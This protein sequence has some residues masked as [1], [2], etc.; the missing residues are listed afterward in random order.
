MNESDAIMRLSAIA[1]RTRMAVFRL[2]VKHGSRGLPATEIARLISIPPTTMSTHLSVLARAELIEARR[3]SR[4]IFYAVRPDGVQSLLSFLISDC[5]EGR[6]ELCS[7]SRAG[8]S[9][10]KI[11]EAS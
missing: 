7:P 4:T 3:E 2:L 9:C 10:D 11:K 1:Q 6:P 8:I 5:C